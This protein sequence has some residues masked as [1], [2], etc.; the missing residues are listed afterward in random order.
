MI[1][2]QMFSVISLSLLAT[3]ALGTQAPLDCVDMF[4]CGFELES[5]INF[6]RWPDDWTRLRD[7]NHPAFLRIGI[8][9]DNAAVGNRCL[10]IQLDGG[11]AVVYS[12]KIKVSSYFSYVLGGFVRTENLQNDVAYC[13]VV[14]YD[15]DDKILHNHSTDFLNHSQWELFHSDSISV[16]DE[17]VQYAIIE[18]HLE[19]QPGLTPDLTGTASFD[20]LWLG[21][22]PRMTLKMD[23][24]N[25]LYDAGNDITADCH[26]S[27]MTD[28]KLQ[29]KFELFDMQGGR[30]AT[31]EKQI[32]GE[33]FLAVTDLKMPFELSSNKTEMKRFH[34][35]VVGWK[36]PV[37]GVGFYRIRVT[38]L[39]VQTSICQTEVSLAV[40]GPLPAVEPSGEFGWTLS[41][42]D[43]RIAM[44]QLVDLVRQAGVSWVKY[45]VWFSEQET[46]QPDKLLSLA[47]RL[48]ENG[49]ELVG[50][51]DQP[52]AAVLPLF[53]EPRP[54]QVAQVFENDGLWKKYLNPVCNHLSAHI[55]W[56]Q[57]GRDKD[58]SFVDHPHLQEK[59]TAVRKELE[60]FG[61]ETHLGFG[62]KWAGEPPAVSNPPWDFIALTS[63]PPLTSNEWNDYL[64]QTRVSSVRRW[65]VME[66]LPSDLYNP[67]IRSGDLV[68]RMVTAKVNAAE[69]VFLSHPFDPQR[70]L[71]QENGTPNDLFLPWRTTSRLLSGTRYLGDLNLPGESHNHVFQKG[72]QAMVVLWNDNPTIE[73]M[74]FGKNVQLM[75][76]WG[77]SVS[78]EEDGNRQIISVGPQPVFLTGVNLSVSCW[79]LGF[80]FDRKNLVSIFN[81]SQ[82]GL[83][84]MVNSFPQ[85][86]TG[87]M[88]VQTPVAWDT[89]LK[90]FHFK[91]AEG[92]GRS[93]P[94]ELRVKPGAHSGSHPVRVDF[95]IS[96]DQI[97][98]FSL[99][100]Y[101]DLGLGDISLEATTRMDDEGNLIVYQQMT[102]HGD[103]VV[104][105]D[106]MLFVS[107]R[108]RQRRYIFNLDREKK[109]QTYILPQGTK[110]LGK[111]IWLRVEEI[112]GDRMLN[113]PI[114]VER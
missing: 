98:Q 11:A 77:Q 55:R 29:I 95:Q 63:T 17:S 83:C 58:V 42:G 78:P 45:P 52:P 10:N 27:G 49:V 44:E 85:G 25:H 84:Q 93:E 94:L 88:T 23:C 86:V 40:M 101:L 35:G 74:F 26:V 91:M 2:S 47:Q 96:A 70:G 54:L 105:F 114:V 57:L 51:L 81:R 18:I 39:G 59:L 19:P 15:A 80:A 109:S 31:A 22:L 64:N 56:W 12:P 110:L 111:T 73:T 75:N 60:R 62:W 48:K 102:N 107:E 5:D 28:S 61:Q 89:H 113:Y 76:I 108:R 99:Y 65:V 38:L 8:E 1:T 72:D 34:T 97:Y 106:C 7:R 37:P 4:R 43:R 24:P 21:R 90:N 71:M 112:G 92:A 69:A 104:N 9:A 67:K 100:R 20:D 30:L 13:R 82:P 16:N 41:A 3:Q 6:D 14:F 33:P 32:E 103:T 46:E 79:R 68:K 66:P 53:G 36:P 87:R 50:M